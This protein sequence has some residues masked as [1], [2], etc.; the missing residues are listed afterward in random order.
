MQFRDN[1]LTSQGVC[2]ILFQYVNTMHAKSGYSTGVYCP[3]PNIETVFKKKN[4]K[5]F[6]GHT[7]FLG[8]LVPLFW[9]CGDVPS[10]FQSQT[11]LPYSHCGGECYVLH[12]PTSWRPA[13]SRSCPH[14]KITFIWLEKNLYV[15]VYNA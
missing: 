9:I 15:N 2:Q 5:V 14:E 6:G 12:L 13:R 8:S 1:S 10:G 4:L 7:S 3:R 11:G